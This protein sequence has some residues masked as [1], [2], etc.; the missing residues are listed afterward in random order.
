MSE[1]QRYLVAVLMADAAAARQ[2][3]GA[4]QSAGMLP[5]TA[6]PPAVPRP[7]TAADL[8]DACVVDLAWLLGVPDQI[9]RAHV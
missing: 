1:A 6:V 7:Q 8:P 3:A 9:G 5:L 2:L 4:L